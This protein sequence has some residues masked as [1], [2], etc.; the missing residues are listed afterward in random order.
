MTARL[1]QLRDLGDLKAQGILTQ[2]EFDA[3]KSAILAS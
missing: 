2:A 3:L 1:A